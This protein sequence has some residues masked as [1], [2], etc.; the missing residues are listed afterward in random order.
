MLQAARI[1]LIV[2]AGLQIAL[3]C[4]NLQPNEAGAVM[5]AVGI[6]NVLHMKLTS[7]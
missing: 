7:L 5:G 4:C 2:Y 1:M 6:K 3:F